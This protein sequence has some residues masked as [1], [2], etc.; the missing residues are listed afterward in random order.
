[1][2]DST[3]LMLAAIAAVTIVMVATTVIGY[4]RS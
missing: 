1:M 2:T 3:I 4:N